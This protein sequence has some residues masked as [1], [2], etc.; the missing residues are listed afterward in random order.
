MESK[1]VLI[2]EDDLIAAQYLRTILEKEG[3]KVVGVIDRGREAIER[4]RTCPVDLVLVDIMLKDDISGIEVA[5]EYPECPI[6]FLSAFADRDMIDQALDSKAIAYL[7]KPYR[8]KE[9]IATVK[10]VLSRDKR[11]EKSLP[12]TSIELKG[13]FRFDFDRD[14]LE[15]NGKIIPLPTTKLRLI[16]LLAL[17]HGN[18]VSPDSLLTYIWDEPKSSSTLRSLINRFRKSVDSQLIENVCGI[19]YRINKKE[20][21][22]DDR[23]E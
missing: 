19:G 14:H 10:L 21:P 9:I 6:I 4:L 22:A 17:H 8:K 13:G 1:R 11:T 2:V 5:L 12:I 7:M 16:R 23:D 20:S 3:L 18:V 15:K